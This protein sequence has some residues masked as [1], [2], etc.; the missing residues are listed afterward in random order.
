MRPKAR[1][2]ALIV[3]TLPDETLVYDERTDKAHCLNSTAA[4][5]WRMAD[6]SHSVDEIARALAVP[7][8]KDIVWT[9][10][11]DLRKA[12]LLEETG[13]RFERPIS[14]RE[15]GKRV[16]AGAA[17]AAI[18][19]ILTIGAPTAVSAASCVQV[20]GSC[21]TSTDCCPVPGVCCRVVGGSKQCKSGAGG[22]L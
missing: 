9:T 19:A 12:K 4:L 21:N 18:P 2:E 17:L 13:G 11:N 20:G 14:R 8:A 7:D 6:G 22:C 3:E 1:T 16:A 5:I 10:L 15:L